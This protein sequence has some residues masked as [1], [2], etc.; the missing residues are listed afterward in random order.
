MAYLE[1]DDDDDDKLDWRRRNGGNW[2]GTV[3]VKAV[4]L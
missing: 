2:R 3:Q 4:D 1:A